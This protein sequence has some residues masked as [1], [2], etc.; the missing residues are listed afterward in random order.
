MLLPGLGR[1]AW[2]WPGRLGVLLVLVL[3]LALVLSL[4]QA[5]LPQ[6]AVG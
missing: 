4:V 2:R 6:P 3:V 1:V 5:P